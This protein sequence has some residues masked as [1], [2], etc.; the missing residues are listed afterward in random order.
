MAQGA[1]LPVF[2]LLFGQMTSSFDPLKG[3]DEMVRLAGEFAIL[4]LILACIGLVT[5]YIGY[6]CWIYIGEAVSSKFRL[7]YFEAL[8]N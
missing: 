7:K 2:G 8:L 5:G 4:F 6:S 3:P 1:A